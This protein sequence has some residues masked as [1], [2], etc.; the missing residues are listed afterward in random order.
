MVAAS[1]GDEGWTHRI[2]YR[3]WK[4]IGLGS[5]RKMLEIVEVLV[6]TGSGF[7][8][9]KIVTLVVVLQLQ[10]LVEVLRKLHRAHS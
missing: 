1:D 2:A 8:Q 9:P 4:W 10:E 5:T 6:A 7:V 3:D